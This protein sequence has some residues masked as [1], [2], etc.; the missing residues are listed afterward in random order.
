MAI[1]NNRMTAIVCHGPEDYRVEQL[2][3]PVPGPQEMVIR[4]SA[5]GI[6]ASD[7]KC[8][9]GAAMFWSGGNPVVK[10]PVVPGH[11][12]FGVVDELGAGAGAHFG[13]KPGDRVVAEQIV[14]CDRCRYLPQRPILDVRN[15]SH[16][17]LSAR[18]G[19]WRHVGLH[20]HSADRARSC[21]SAG[22]AAGGR[23]HHR[24]AVLRHP[25][26]QSRWHPTGRH[27]G[28]RR[29]RADR[30]DDGPGGTAENP[31]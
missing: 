19:G 1:K 27:G 29:R 6:C 14:P 8:W 7:C 25:H 23:G 17:R 13:V 21:H 28:D 22:H 31:A 26:H 12:F 16:L 4:I 15:P 10:P 24:A 18:R 30:A 11:E 20:A 3:R 5:C 9:S 2:D